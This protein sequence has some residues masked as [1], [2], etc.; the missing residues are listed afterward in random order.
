VKKN[1]ESIS[2][3]DISAAIVTPARPYKTA[4]G[5]LGGVNRTFIQ[6]VGFLECLSIRVKMRVAMEKLAISVLINNQKNSNYPSAFCI[7]KA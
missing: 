1:L 2:V 5:L 4:D 7:T 6:G 3:P